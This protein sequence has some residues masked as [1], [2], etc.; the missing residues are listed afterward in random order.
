MPPVGITIAV[1]SPTPKQLALVWVTEVVRTAG[2]KIVTLSLEEIP[3][4]SVTV[5]VK[6]PED[7][8]EV[9]CVTAPFDHAKVYGKVPPIGETDAV[10]SP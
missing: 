2:S 6:L 8:E 5:T 4:A 9:L 3:Q 7:K 1:P 10:P